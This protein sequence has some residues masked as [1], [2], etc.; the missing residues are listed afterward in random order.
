MTEETPTKVL[1][2]LAVA[3][4]SMFLLFVVASSDGGARPVPDPF[5]PTNV[6]A[7]L[8]NVSAG[9]SGFLAQNLIEPVKA[10]LT[11]YAET[12]DWIID[13]ADF[14]ILEAVGLENLAQIKEP[15]P[16]VAGA[17]I[18]SGAAEAPA[19]AMQT[20]RPMS[21]LELLGF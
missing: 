8:D 11:Y 13:N 6:M 14:A 5:N 19:Y 12:G 20:Y 10:D 15:A 18:E 17:Y 3:L 21:L 1:S 9:Y 7:V 16:Q 2:L 4:S